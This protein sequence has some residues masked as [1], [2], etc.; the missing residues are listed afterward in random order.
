MDNE[1]S[2]CVGEPQ[3]QRPFWRRELMRYFVIVFFLV[4]ITA[5][6]I[7]F[8]LAYTHGEFTPEQIERMKNAN[9][10]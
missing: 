4:L 8:W 6:V 7:C 5:I 9:P 3:K 1:Q 10:W 2:N